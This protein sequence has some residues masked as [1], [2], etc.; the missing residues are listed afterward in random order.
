MDCNW[1][2]PHAWGEMGP[3]E[4][5]WGNGGSYTSYAL[6]RDLAADEILQLYSKSGGS[7]CG[8]LLYPVSNVKAG[9]YQTGP[10]EE[11]SCM[12]MTASS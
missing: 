4:D 3:N 7:Y 6:S 8:T 11:F 2:N 9:C 10:G 5:T 12:K 1:R